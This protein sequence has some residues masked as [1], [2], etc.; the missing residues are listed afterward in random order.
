MLDQAPRRNEV[1]ISAAAVEIPALT[2]IPEK[3]ALPAQVVDLQAP[4]DR[5]GELKRETSFLGEFL[6]LTCGT[7]GFLMGG[8]AGAALGSAVGQLTGEIATKQTRM[9]WPTLARAFL[10]PKGIGRKEIVLIVIAMTVAI[11]SDVS[12]QSAQLTAL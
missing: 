3:A 4:T 8:P 2:G 12:A 9:I 7:A 6:R 1:R 11:P 5:P 10:S